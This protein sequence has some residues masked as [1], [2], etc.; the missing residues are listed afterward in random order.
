MIEKYFY[1]D[2]QTAHELLEQIKHIEAAKRGIDRQAF[3]LGDYVVLS[4]ERLKLRNVVMRDDELAYLDEIIKTLNMLRERGIAVIP[5]LGY[6]YDPNSRD[7]RGYLFQLRAKG[8]E[9]YDDAIMTKFCVWAQNKSEGA[10]LST[11]LNDNEAADYLTFRTH[12]IS[13]VLQDHFDRFI[14]DMLQILDEDILIDCNGKSNFFYDSKLGFQYIDLDAHNDY[15]YGFISAKP[16]IKEIV[17]YCGF[18][19]CHY[20]EGTELFSNAALEEKAICLLGDSRL[21]NLKIDNQIVFEKCMLALRH[22][23]IPEYMIKSAL[24]KIKILGY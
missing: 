8:T 17:S 21:H 10:Y 6:C 11:Y 20:A 18:V 9:L 16:D 5:I 4:T 7:G 1:I 24:K 13:Q 15:K 23:G 12:T 3:L 22:N 19:P 14:Y 2:C